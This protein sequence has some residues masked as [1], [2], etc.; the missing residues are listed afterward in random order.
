M[1]TDSIYRINKAGLYVTGHVRSSAIQ[2]LLGNPGTC[3]SIDL[4]VRDAM[5]LL[6]VLGIDWEDGV[7]LNE[8]LKDEFVM[9]SDDEN[10]HSLSIGDPY[11]N[12]SV[13]LKVGLEEAR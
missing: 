2:L 3:R 4:N 10:G 7:F 13:D 11:G 1:T 12:D 9:V 6:D 8:A 5:G